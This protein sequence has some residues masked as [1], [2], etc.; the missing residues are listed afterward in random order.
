MKRTFEITTS[1]GPVSGIFGRAAESAGKQP[2]LLVAIHGGTYSS[3]YFDIPGHSL[4]DRAM[5]AGFDIIAPDR[6]GYGGTEPLKDGPEM[7]DRNA[8]RLADLMGE[9][10]GALD[11][12]PEGI[13]LIGHSMGG[14][15]AAS[16]AA[17]QPDWPLR[18]IMVTGFAQTLPA[19]L[20]EDF[21]KLPPGYFVELP[22]ALKDQVMFGPPDTLP[23]TMPAASHPANTQ[24]PRAEAIDIAGDWGQ[25]APGLL[26]QV[27]VPVYYKLAQHEQ[28]W[29]IAD[30]ATVAAMFTRAP[31]V[32]TGLFAGAG[33]CIDFHRRSGDFH[34][35]MLGFAAAL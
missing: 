14:V 21:A 4:I 22:T 30:Q 18:G 11:L 15:I 17:R 10:T 23:E 26:G 31:K 12:Q 25:R 7:L 8:A 35:E 13:A 6:P 3:R 16:I 34:D 9:I 5:A 1:Q 2:T 24:M 27:S 20:A 19:H 33:H 32:E 28:L 29:H